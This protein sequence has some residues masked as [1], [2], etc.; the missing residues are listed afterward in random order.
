MMNRILLSINSIE[1]SESAWDEVPQQNTFGYDMF[2]YE[3]LTYL[4]FICTTKRGPKL[5]PTK[6]LEG[7]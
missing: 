7:L 6:T 5:P 3:T 1:K 4:C 2:D